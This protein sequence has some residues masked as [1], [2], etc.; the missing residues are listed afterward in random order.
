MSKFSETYNVCLYVI[1]IQRKK[2][3]KKC[4]KLGYGI[5]LLNCGAGEDSWDSLGQQG[6]QASQC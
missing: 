3:Q 6:D 5:M 4:K 1:W 2:Q